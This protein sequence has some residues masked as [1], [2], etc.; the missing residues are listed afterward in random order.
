MQKVTLRIENRHESK[1][2]TLDDEL[3]IGRTD[4]ASVVLSDT[5]LSR[6]N[7]TFFRDGEQVLVVDENSLNG[8]ILNGERISG[9]PVRVFD[10]DTI[11]IG[12]ETRIR[13]EIGEKAAARGVQTAAVGQPPVNDQPPKIKESGSG[14]SKTKNQNQKTKSG[15]P[16]IVLVAAGSTVLILLFGVV[17]LLVASQLDDGGNKTKPTPGVV[18]SQVIPVRV[19]DPLGGEDPEDISDIIA[20]WEIEEKELDV[21]T[22][23]DVKVTEVNASKDEAELNVTAAFLADR[24][25]RA[26]EKR[27][28]EAGIRPAGLDVPKELFG[29]GVIKQK[30]KL[31]EMIKKTPPYEQ[32]M[33]FSD[34]A[35]KRLSGELREMPMATDSFYLEVGGSAQDT[36]FTAFSFQTDSTPI[37]SGSPKYKPLADLAQK[38]GVSLDNSADR[39]QIRMRLLRMFNPRAND[40]LREIANAYYKEFNRPLRVTSL[41]RSMDY[42]ILLNATN[43]NSF[44]VRGAGSL[45]PHTSGCAFDLA[46]KHMGVDEQNFVMKK[47]A[48]MERD[49]KLDALIEYGTN[50]CFHIFIYYDGIAPSF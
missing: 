20:G 33:D 30:F 42:Q 12:S 48:E 17:A 49:R 22:V 3:S 5:G 45:P 26:L 50:A 14:N 28:K 38:Y 1:T 19:I 4:S 18:K 9:P 16:V 31:Q 21:A 23:Q 13:V 6:K 32:P 10:G 24:K 39:K 35:A 25:A 8:T 47:L 34:L 7:T 36:P 43:A 15:P 37:L 41:T 29:D 40:V 46:R 44:K 11:S 2:V 27:A